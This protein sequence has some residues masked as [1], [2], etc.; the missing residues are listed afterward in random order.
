MGLRGQMQ[1]SWNSLHQSQQE[2]GENAPLLFWKMNGKS[3]AEIG[4]LAATRV[5]NFTRGIKWF[6]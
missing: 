3:I 5:P 1:S 4:I 2:M 6:L